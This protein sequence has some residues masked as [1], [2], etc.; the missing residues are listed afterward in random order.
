MIKEHTM[1]K[2]ITL[3]SLV[4]LLFSTSAYAAHLDDRERKHMKAP[5]KHIIKRVDGYKRI[6]RPHRVTQHK[7]VYRPNVN[8]RRHVRPS[9]RPKKIYPRRPYI[10][11]HI[12]RPHRVV[13]HHR[14]GHRV[15]RLH[16]N[17]FHFILGGLSYHYYSGAFYRPYQ[18]GYRI[19]GAPIGAVIYTLPRGYIRVFINNR[20]YYMY[21]NIYYLRDRNR[22]YRVVE[23]PTTYTTTVPNNTTYQYQYGD[24]A[25]NLPAGAV[26]VI[27]DGTHYYE[28]GNQYFRPSRRDGQTIYTVVDMY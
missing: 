17:A 27:I 12:P 26:E 25:L 11:H 14:P 6:V 21:E 20:N 19:V 9:M 16:R 23:T 5:K 7:K 22:G 10:S 2:I 1:R 28:Y 8:S 3:S 15:H 4:L 13:L 18:G 24:V